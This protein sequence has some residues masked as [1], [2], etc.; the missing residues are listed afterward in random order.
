[1]MAS[2]PGRTRHPAPL[3]GD[4][5]RGGLSAPGRARLLSCLWCGKLRRTVEL[6][7]RFHPSCRLVVAER[8]AGLPTVMR[9]PTRRAWRAGF[10]P[11]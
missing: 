9:A 6:A 7:D 11:D 2:S 8:A 10:G 4:P 5:S 1:M 3:V